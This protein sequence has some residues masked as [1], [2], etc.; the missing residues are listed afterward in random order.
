[1]HHREKSTSNETGNTLINKYTDLC[2]SYGVD[3]DA[4]VLV[5][6]RFG[7]KKLR[8][9]PLFGDKGMLPL[10]D[11]LL[12][13]SKSDQEP[14]ALTVLDF[15]Q[16]TITSHGAIA[17]S[18]ILESN[19]GLKEI[20]LQHNKIGTHGA[21]AIADS[22][23]GHPSI[24]IVNLRGCAVGERGA[25]MLCSRLLNKATAVEF[26]DLS[27]NVMGMG[28]M[29]AIND[30]LLKRQTLKLPPIEVDLQGNA[31]TE[32]VMNAV[33][34]G[35]GFVLCIVGTVFMGMKTAER[36][37]TEPDGLVPAKHKWCISIYCISL[38]VLYIS[39]TLY[40]SFFALTNTRKIFAIFDQVQCVYV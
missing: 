11:V 14:S 5:A 29:G 36:G 6:L 8:A 38:C 13:V 35:L 23:A 27:L 33:T 7:R 20:R 34:H 30:A 19:I 32:E 1:M 12:K 26:L 3:T 37:M 28:G 9:S 40:H 39:S 18:K 24:K 16:A 15:S 4:G 31:V 10:A 22:L 2:R 17:L 21:K 25:Y